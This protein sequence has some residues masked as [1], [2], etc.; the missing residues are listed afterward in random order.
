MQVNV[1]APNKT[2]RT[3]VAGMDVSS[4]VAIELHNTELVPWVFNRPSFWVLP[5]PRRCLA[6][7]NPLARRMAPSGGNSA[8]NNWWESSDLLLS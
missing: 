2:W 1:K 5:F 6:S 8:I 3:I 7:I 4:V